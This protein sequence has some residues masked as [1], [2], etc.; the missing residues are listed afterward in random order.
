[1][2]SNFIVDVRLKENDT[3]SRA[4]ILAIKSLCFEFV[5]DRPYAASLRQPCMLRLLQRFVAPSLVQT[6]SLDGC[7]WLDKSCSC[8]WSEMLDLASYT[9]RQH[10]PCS[11]LLG[12]NSQN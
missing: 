11:L 4:L 8:P 10:Q 7:S 12:H 3:V 2:P 1:M 6:C 9:R 5:Y